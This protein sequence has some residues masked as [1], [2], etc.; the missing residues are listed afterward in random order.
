MGTRIYVGNLPVGIIE[1]E[2]EE[3]FARFGPLKS[4]WVA[5]K[6]PGFAFVEYSDERD[7]DDAVK[8]MDGIRGWVR[9]E[10][11]FLEEVQESAGRIEEDMAIVAET[12]GEG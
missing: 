10:W 6:P 5:R 8:G 1:S 12:G 7:A 2:L 3:E 9:I 4:L 11:S